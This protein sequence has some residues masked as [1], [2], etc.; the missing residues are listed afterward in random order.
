MSATMHSEADSTW[1][2]WF[3]NQSF[4]HQGV[5]AVG[6][7]QDV[8]AAVKQA[9][10]KGLSLRTAGA[11]HSNT[12]IVETAGHFL[13]TTALR[14]IV[15]I[16]RERRLATVRAH[17]T[18]AE[19]AEP[20]WQAGLAL[21]NQGDIDAQAI[22][23][24]I[25]TATHGSGM[26]LG[27]FSSVMRAC[28][29]V[30]GEGNLQVIDQASPAKLAAAQCA[31]GM[32]GI[33][34]EVTL[35]V[36]PAYHL[37]EEILFIH[38]DEVRERWDEFQAGYRHFSFFWMPTER[39]AQLY[40]Y[41]QA[42]ADY[43]MVKLYNETD[44]RPGARTLPPGERI[45]RSYRIYP[46][47][48]DPNFHEMEYFVPASEAREAFEEQRELMLAALPDSIFPMEVRFVAADNAWLSPNYQ[49]ANMV[50][51]ISGQPGTNYGPYLQ[52][53]D[54]HFRRRSGRPHWGKLHF[55]TA[56]RLAA[57]FPKYQDFRTLRAEFD[58]AGRFLNSHLSGLFE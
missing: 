1:T 49:R 25:S 28:R 20:L 54:D 23:G 21:T 43:C 27:N 48:Y 51:S 31:I 12:P 37:H 19:L 38:V 11:G 58:P 32:L 9:R 47:V 24:A 29:I 44:E 16:D 6:T 13:D 42:R 41:D 22:A 4:R 53:C 15:S 14:G 33:I 35:E 10:E 7:E 34:T 52:K 30:D 50:I 26:A 36:S 57:L 2:N 45:D 40:G 18:I 17:T 39:S 56:E 55:M 46:H 5:L 3:G 8:I